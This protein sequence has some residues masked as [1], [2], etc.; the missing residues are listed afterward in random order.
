VGSFRGDDKNLH[1]ALR[2][3]DVFASVGA[4]RFDLTHIDI[5]G[6]KR[7]FRML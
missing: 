5:D 1:D 6:K 4:D 7:G 2:L 3:I